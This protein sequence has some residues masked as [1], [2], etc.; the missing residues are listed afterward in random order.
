MELPRVANIRM[1]LSSKQQTKSRPPL[2]EWESTGRNSL[3]LIPV[4]SPVSQFTY[5]IMNRSL[6]SIGRQA[7]LAFGLFALSFG[8]SSCGENLEVSPTA[9]T[10]QSADT[11]LKTTL[12]L[13]DVVVGA[14]DNSSAPATRAIY[15]YADVSTALPR[16]QAGSNFKAVLSF[17]NKTRGTKAWTEVN[18]VVAYDAAGKLEFKIKYP[19]V[20][21]TSLG[22]TAFTVAANDEVYINAVMGG[23]KATASSGQLNVTFSPADNTGKASNDVSV[24]FYTGWQPLQVNADNTLSGNVSFTP[25]GTLVVARVKRDAAISSDNS[26]QL[27]STSLASTATFNM[28]QTTNLGQAATPTAPTYTVGGTTTGNYYVQTGRNITTEAGYDKFIFWGMP[29]APLGGQHATKVLPAKGGYWLSRDNSNNET[30]QAIYA[31]AMPTG[32]VLRFTLKP[33]VPSDPDYYFLNPLARIAERN[34]GL[35]P[36]TFATDDTP[37]TSVYVWWRQYKDIPTDTNLQTTKW[38]PADYKMPTLYE[39]HAA[40]PLINDDPQPGATYKYSLKWPGF[41]LNGTTPV[42]V[43]EQLSLGNNG[44]TSQNTYQWDGQT[45]WYAIRWAS[46]NVTGDKLRCAYRYEIL[47]WGTPSAQLRVTSRYLGEHF[48]HVSINDVANTAYW[49]ANIPA[50]VVR[51]FPITGWIDTRTQQNNVTVSDLGTWLLYWTRDVWGTGTDANGY[52]TDHWA[53]QFRYWG[54]NPAFE[55]FHYVNGDYRYPVRPIAIDP[56]YKNG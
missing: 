16:L 53:A 31:Q 2:T 13:G 15:D 37:A 34:I 20:S 43:K 9:S 33:T 27:F 26:Y 39:F 7:L 44:S 41:S 4:S 47:N 45:T 19:T 22:T 3:F 54:K 24:P 12:H 38:M 51:I 6:F 30:F 25:Q 36:G 56:I 8:V 1:A 18:W 10:E 55:R 32:G 21:V 49:S 14:A 40:F 48:T 52:N 5:T 28:T 35:T 29:T 46:N 17:Y 42:S 23:G 50:D 11:A